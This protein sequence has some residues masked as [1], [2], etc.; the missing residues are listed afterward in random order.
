MLDH[1]L[2][3]RIASKRQLKQLAFV[4]GSPA[5]QYI[6]ALWWNRFTEFEQNTLKKGYET[7]T[8]HTFPTNS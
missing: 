1:A 4:K 6:H 8:C 5:T 2:D 7:P 3:D